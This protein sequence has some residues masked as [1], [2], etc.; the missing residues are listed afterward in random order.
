MF[1]CEYFSPSTRSGFV[2]WFSVASSRLDTQMLN[3][4]PLFPVSELFP[5][6][7]CGGLNFNDVVHW[8]LLCVAFL[9]C[10]ATWCPV[11]HV[12]LTIVNRRNF[13][14]GVPCFMPHFQWFKSMRI[15]LWDNR[16]AVESFIFRRLFAK[17]ARVWWKLNNVQGNYVVAVLEENRNSPLKARKTERREH[18]WHI[19]SPVRLWQLLRTP[20]FSRHLIPTVFSLEPETIG[21]PDVL[22]FLMQRQLHSLQQSRLKATAV[23]EGSRVGGHE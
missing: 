20:C 23:A 16:A 22:L 7:C 17:S 10:V 6:T 21:A 18:F 11:H 4:S 9:K 3:M 12:L 2:G 15:A 14:Q 13:T 8:T 5:Q 19:D 1:C